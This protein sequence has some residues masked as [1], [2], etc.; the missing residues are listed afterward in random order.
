MTNEFAT[1]IRSL[2]GGGV[3]I[4][5]QGAISGDVSASRPNRAARAHADWTNPDPDAQTRARRSRAGF[6]VERFM[7]FAS[8]LAHELTRR[9]A[10][11]KFMADYTA[12]QHAT[13]ERHRGMEIWTNRSGLARFFAHLEIEQHVINGNAF[14]KRAAWERWDNGERRGRDRRRDL[15][16][17]QSYVREFRGQNF[18]IRSVR[19]QRD[20]SLI[21]FAVTERQRRG[22]KAPRD[23]QRRR[24][25]LFIS[26]GDSQHTVRRIDVTPISSNLVRLTNDLAMALGGEGK[27]C[28]PPR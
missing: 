4:L 17:N 9:F 28:N 5:R 2:A 25:R 22:C 10:F 1:F 16:V 21:C 27:Y 15:D 12:L 14:A 19:E 18:V 8:A 20:R 11:K 26:H 24:K 7:H 23:F 13:L 6:T 3:D